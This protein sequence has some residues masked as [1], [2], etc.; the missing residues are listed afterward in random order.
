MTEAKQQTRRSQ[1]FEGNEGIDF[2]RCRICGDYRRVIS[3]RH[4]SKHGI[5]RETY[6]EEYHLSPDELI[7]K[8]FRMIQ[9]SRREYYPYGKRDWIAAIKKVYRS[10]GDISAGYLQD[11]YP[12]IYVQ[13]VW[14]YGDWDKALSAAGFN[15]ERNATTPILERE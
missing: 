3:G 1:R 6:M 10:G 7:A 12:H 11:N 2:V 9:S 8:A 14:L 13:G 5:E 4:L 15:P